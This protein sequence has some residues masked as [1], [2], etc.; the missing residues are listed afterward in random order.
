MKRNILSLATFL[1]LFI[2]ISAYTQTLPSGFSIQQVG[3]S[4]NLVSMSFAPDGRI[5]LAEQTGKVK[6]VKNGIIQ[7]G[8]LI[9]LDSIYSQKE[10][11]LLGIA[12]DPNF[13][14]NGYVYFYYTINVRGNRYNG[15][16]I[17]GTAQDPP[18]RHKIARYTMS[19]DQILSASKLTVIDLDITT[20][21]ATN[22]NHD[23]GTMRFGQ[24]GK[25]YVATG[26]GDLW[27]NKQCMSYTQ[28]SC[29]CGSTW[30]PASWANDNNTFQGKIL[31]MNADGTA[32]SDN[33]YFSSPTPV[34]YE[35][36]Y[37]YAKG[38][39]N[40][41]TMNFKP[42]TN[43]LY[44]NDVGSS[45]AS[46]REEIN[47]LTPT[48]K[49][50]FG[51]QAPGGGEGILNNANY[52]DPIYAYL[53]GTTTATGCGI[54]GGTFY[55]TVSGGNT[56]WPSQYH[57]K[58]FYMDFC[59]GYINTI[60][61]D[62]GNQVQNFAR[63]LTT[64]FNNANTGFGI[65]N[66]EESPDGDMYFIVRSLTAGQSGLYKL[67]YQTVSV[68]GITISGTSTTINTNSGNIQFTGGIQPS[69]A[70]N[71]KINWNVFPSSIA[72][73]NSSGLLT[74]LRNGIVT[75]TGIADGNLSQRANFVV[76][77]T[78]QDV[79]TNIS[80]SSIGNSF[81]ISSLR[82]T[83]SLT[84][85]IL[86]STATQTISWSI[87]SYSNNA[88]SLISSNGVITA[89]GE[90]GF[91][92]V[93]GISVVDNS[94]SQKVVITVSGQNIPVTGLSIYSVEGNEIT[95]DKATIEIIPTFTPNN[96]SNQNVNWVLSDTS[97]ASI[98][99]SGFL[100]ALKNGVLT[101][102]AISAENSTI[103]SSIVINIT[104]QVTSTTGTI[105]GVNTETNQGFIVYPNPNSGTFTIE[106]DLVK[107]KDIMVY[108]MN[109]QGVDI[110][111]K[112]ITNFT[113]KSQ[114]SV[115]GV[116]AGM[117]RVSIS[118]GLGSFHQIII[119]H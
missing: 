66:L 3:A 16:L 63:G 85:S 111:S 52:E 12:F 18:I 47:K 14:N 26:E 1:G 32:P 73:I 46:R 54:V 23:G 27:C 69:N 55:T 79:P 107:G 72:G 94:I 117:Y 86:P 31:R 60:D 82:G 50:H 104:N 76:T 87:V 10:K 30:I 40:P 28:N 81:T 37:F 77:I 45:G 57:N 21:F 11:G 112:K 70:T 99:N 102:T 36:K 6:L 20:G 38:F 68:S 98:D 19:G 65:L 61:F 96:A 95:V 25:L 101:V 105:L 53:D 43:D 15:T 4:N 109:Q 90:N 71:T 33:P 110:Y 91:I 113:G 39:R 114:I 83:L 88:T 42:G 84:G 78:N 29:N 115:P 35:Q 58:Y 34:Q 9:T 97:L 51:W 74:A 106:N 59:N 5:L 62:N 93:V 103:S 67:S 80:I 2:G 17:A 24:D 89:T 92:T 8:D 64:N 49:K 108:L 75:V 13:V 119:I 118:V 100:T 48:S 41:F 22:F 56:P 44:I 116:P 7:P